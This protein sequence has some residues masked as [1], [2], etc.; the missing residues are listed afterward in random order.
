M[1]RGSIDGSVGAEKDGSVFEQNLRRK[2]MELL[3]NQSLKTT[4]TTS[5]RNIMSN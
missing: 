1:V 4:L 2:Q 3:Q 5:I